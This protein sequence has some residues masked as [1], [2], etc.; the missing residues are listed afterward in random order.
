MNVQLNIEELILHGFAALDRRQ[1]GAAV[2]AELT[3]LFREQG[4]PPALL[5]GGAL[6]RLDGGAFT[7]S[8]DAKA[9]QI[10]AQV[11]QA[12]YGGLAR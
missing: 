3:R 7:V 8:P 11:A 1:I 6:V 12:L 9:V 5:N 10:G 2:G 4:V